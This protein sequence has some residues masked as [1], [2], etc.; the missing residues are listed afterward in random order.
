MV[1]RT[2]ATVFDEGNNNSSLDLS[3][4]STDR[5]THEYTQTHT[6]TDKET[7]TQTHNHTSSPGTPFAAVLPPA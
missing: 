7:D 6:D 3:W 4:P 1:V 5:T 2:G